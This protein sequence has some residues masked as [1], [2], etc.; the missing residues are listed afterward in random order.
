MN[1]SS[2]GG[3]FDTAV[4]KNPNLSKTDKFSYLSSYLTGVATNV[5]G[6]PLTE[7]HYDNAIQLL[8]NGIGRRDLVIMHI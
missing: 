3:Q 4:H 5:A 7:A 6:F 8:H 1:G 2:F